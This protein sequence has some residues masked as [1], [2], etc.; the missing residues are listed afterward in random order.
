MAH[1]VLRGCPGPEKSSR[2]LGSFGVA[3]VGTCV[4][5]TGLVLVLL[6]RPGNRTR[7]QKVLRWLRT[8]ERHLRQT[9]SC[10]SRGRTRRRTGRTSGTSRRAGRWGY[11]KP[12][13]PWGPEESLLLQLHSLLQGPLT[14][15]L[16]GHKELQVSLALVW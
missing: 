15:H 11:C 12:S 5:G 1:A 16:T 8:E 13:G 4:L 3:L 10:W 7:L 2:V 6:R 9:F 14:L